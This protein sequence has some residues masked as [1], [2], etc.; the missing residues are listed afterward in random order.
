MV[1]RVRS[2][3]GARR[4]A[5]LKE[6]NPIAVDDGVVVF[7]IPTHLHFLLE[8]LEADKELHAILS[9]LAEEMIDTPI[10]L[11]FVAGDGEQ[12]GDEPERAPNKDD[13]DV[14]GSDAGADPTRLVADLLGGEVVTE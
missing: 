13:L 2:D 11:R 6:A 5:Y 7:E 8:Q 4:H 3:V 10:S 14:E 1:A 9:T 12:T